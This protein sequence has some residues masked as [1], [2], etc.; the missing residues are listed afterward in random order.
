MS[1]KWLPVVGYEGLYEVSN[2]GNVRSLFRYKKQLKPS[3]GSN[4]YLS[5]ELFK[6]K[7][8]K[9]ISIHRIVAIA[10]IPNPDNLPIVNHKDENKH[11]NCVEN[12]EWVTS[13]EN[14]T[15]GTFTQRRV[16]NTNYAKSC[17]AENARK[18]GVKVSKPVLQFTKDGAFV[19]RYS[20]GK[21]AHKMTGLNHS[22]IL[23]C[24]A[25][26]RYKTVGGFVWKYDERNDDLLAS[27]F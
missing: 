17:Y 2:K 27:P 13:Q 3:K 12:L 15:Y 26:K 21:E 10:F 18:N 11:N 1:E 20:S 7:Q 22:H 8:G 5:V 16:S 25:G 4:G 6:N 9:R 24:C 19:N 23:E 14:M